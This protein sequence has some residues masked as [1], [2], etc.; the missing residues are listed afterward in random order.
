MSPSNEQKNLNDLHVSL[1]KV[2]IDLQE[3]SI[4]T[5]WATHKV[6]GESLVRMGGLISS[7][8]TVLQTGVAH[9]EDDCRVKQFA[10]VAE[11]NLSKIMDMLDGLAVSLERS[12]IA[13][14]SQERKES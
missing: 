4:N 8:R 1:L 3:R 11:Q 9:A 14:E 10:K 2:Q 7:I 12:G 5:L 6:I 13:A